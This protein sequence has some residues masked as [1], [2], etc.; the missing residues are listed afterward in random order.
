LNHTLDADDEYIIRV[1]QNYLFL[2]A[3]KDPTRFCLLCEA[4]LIVTSLECRVPLSVL[5]E[6][7]RTNYTSLDALQKS[8]V[9][10]A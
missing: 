8:R 9:G 7:I 5:I 10:D 6:E 3:G 2:H 1:V 4:L